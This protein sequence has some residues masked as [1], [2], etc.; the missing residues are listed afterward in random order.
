MSSVR[1]I[2]V[3]KKPDYAVLAKELKAEI[4][5]YLGIRT[6]ERVRV[7]IRYDV[8]NIS[9]ET[10]KRAVHTVFSEPPVDDVYEETFL[11]A[12]EKEPH[13]FCV[14]YLPGQFDQRADSA[15]QCVKLLKEDEDP[16]IRSATVYVIEG[17]LSEEEL[18]SIKAHCINPVDSREADLSKPETLLAHFEEP[19][20]VAEL[21]A[22]AEQTEEAFYAL[23]DSLHL[24]MTYQDFLHIRTY[25]EKEEK[26]IRR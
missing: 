25:F 14:E 26:E 12:N 8:E 22:F 1:R 16:V 2:Y 20:D 9:D 4:Q 18:C 13:V 17:V 24:A 6:V 23:Y 7:L 15:Q 10:F 3:E 19:D 11:A 21:E 5:G